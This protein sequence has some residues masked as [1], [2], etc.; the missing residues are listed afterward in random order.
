[1][2][3]ELVNLKKLKADIDNDEKMCFVKKVVIKP[4]L[5]V[6]TFKKLLTKVMPHKVCIATLK[7]KGWQVASGYY[8]F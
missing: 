3:F 2:R 4:Y 6:T 5:L 1:M 7:W 8:H